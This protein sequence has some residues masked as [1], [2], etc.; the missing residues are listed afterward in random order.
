MNRSSFLVGLG[1]TGILLAPL[2]VAGQNA[3][4]TASPVAAG[5]ASSAAGGDRT[6]LAAV[7]LSAEDLPAGFFG[8][9]ERYFLSAEGV[10]T[11][12][13][14]GG[15]ALDEIRTLSLRAMYDSFYQGPDERVLYIYVAELGSPAEVEA[16]FS[17]LENEALIYGDEIGVLAS[18]DLPGP[19]IGDE[20]AETT[21]AV[22]DYGVWGG[23]IVEQTSVTFTVGSFLLGVGLEVPL[24]DGSAPAATPS[25]AT[26]TAPDAESLRLVTDTAIKLEA[27]LRAVEAGEDPSGVNS[28]LPPLLLPT[29]Q[30]WPRPG[31]AAE[32]YKDASQ[33]LGSVGPAAALADQFRGAYAR[34]VAPGTRAN[35]L[36]PQPPFL[37][38]GVSTFDSSE[39]A[40]SL[41]TEAGD[42]PVPG[43][44]PQPSVQDLVDGPAVPGADESATYRSAFE[45]G[46]AVDSARAA[47]VVGDRF[48]TI[49]LQGAASEEEALAVVRDLAAQQASC[50]TT[51]D[52]CA[53]LVPPVALGGGDSVP[54]PATPAP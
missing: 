43:P 37:S 25:V 45:P 21:V 47:F 13:A 23:P 30:V 48:V 14:Y 2:A 41:L 35:D 19:A 44:L 1:L 22:L 28:T 53:T 49:D 20:P 5:L 34:T 36:V 50:L 3:S 46:G 39:A 12:F 9:D 11:F 10:A 51:G 6:D 29:D 16:A 8:F 42:L 18:E 15:G 54:F 4:P 33:I 38:I 40:L 52:V 31:L 24:A 17:V 26:P 32:G 7:A 27:R